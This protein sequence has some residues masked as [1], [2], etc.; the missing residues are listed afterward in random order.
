MKLHIITNLS[1]MH[2]FVLK[3]RQRHLIRRVR[4][5]NPDLL[6]LVAPDSGGVSLCD[7]PTNYTVIN[8][9]IDNTVMILGTTSAASCTI[10]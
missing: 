5:L 1:Y 6:R 10:T 2:R 7:A 8:C 3:L 9:D 4:V